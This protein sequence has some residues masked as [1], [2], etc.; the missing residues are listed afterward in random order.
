MRE[1]ITAVLGQI[2]G[3]PVWDVTRGPG[4]AMFQI[5]QRQTVYDRSGNAR[6]LGTFALHIQCPWRIVGPAG[7]IVG[8]VERYFPPGED[9]FRDGET[10]DWE[11]PAITRFEER[12]GTY[13]A[14]RA[15]MPPVV[16]AIA[17]DRVGGFQLA[18]DDGAT[19]EVFPDLT[20]GEHWRLFNPG[21][22]DRHFV[23]IAGAIEE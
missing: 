20:F 23:V 1:R 5:G 2:I 3:L 7:I 17:A 16:S 14:E 15:A 22:R 13:F 11:V 18:L 4:I 9:P 6:E 19:I 8:W 21:N 10:F 12:I